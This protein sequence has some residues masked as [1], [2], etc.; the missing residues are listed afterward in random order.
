MLEKLIPTN[1]LAV[2]IGLLVAVIVV[3]VLT[4]PRRRTWKR[5]DGKRWTR[6][7]NRKGG[8]GVPIRPAAESDRPDAAEQLRRVMAAD[9]K[10]CPLLNKSEA[11]VFKELEV[12][13]KAR[14]PTWKVMAQVSLGEFLRSPD[15]SAFFSVNSKRVDFALMDEACRVRHA[16]EYQGSGHHLPGGA[17]AARDAV[18]KEALRKA[19]IG[20]H[21]VVAGHT[22]PAEL[23]RLV[24]KLV[25][26]S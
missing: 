21:E 8:Q 4:G 7:D 23:K 18:K 5:R 2:L 24:E 15:T 19:G 20:Y 22:T 25:V 3:Q 14:N 13:V 26:G 17:A 6:G 10:S 9:F 11:A 1:N 16:I 12:A